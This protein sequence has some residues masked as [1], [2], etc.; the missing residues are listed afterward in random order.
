M[1]VAVWLLVL[2]AAGAAQDAIAVGRPLLGGPEHENGVALIREGIATLEKGPATA[3]ALHRIGLGYFY[4]EEDAKAQAAFAKAAALE[5]ENPEHVFMLGVTQAYSDPAKATA[6]MRKAIELDPKNAGYRFEL[7][8][9]LARQEHG[10][11]T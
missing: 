9:L 1:R 2:A 3:K 4:L 10:R 11:I 8:R 7:G 5:P 6:T